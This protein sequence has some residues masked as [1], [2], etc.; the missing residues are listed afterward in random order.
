MIE[1]SSWLNYY[2]MN[3][4]IKEQIILG[5]ATNPSDNCTHFGQDQGISEII[6]F[7]KN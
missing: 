2:G 5:K 1:L 6:N 3:D 4:I 7:T